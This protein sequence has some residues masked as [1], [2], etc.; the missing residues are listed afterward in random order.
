MYD[1][2]FILQM[3]PILNPYFCIFLFGCIHALYFLYFNFVFF[4]LE[5]SSC[6]EFIFQG[7]MLVCFYLFKGIN[8][9]TFQLENVLFSKNMPRN[10]V[11][12][13]ITD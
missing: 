5:H 2:V 4:Y 3:K 6:E 7:I 9:T 12:S 11:F 13:Q 10:S 8:L 1:V